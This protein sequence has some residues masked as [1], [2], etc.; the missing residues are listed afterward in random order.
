MIFLTSY[1]EIDVAVTTLKRGAE[2]SH[3]P[4]APDRLLTVVRE[5]LA[6][7]EKRRA[8]SRDEAACPQHSHG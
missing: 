1:A 3:Q 7:D 2:T 4:V 5:A 8:A 6:A